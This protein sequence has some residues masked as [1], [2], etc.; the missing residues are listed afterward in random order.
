MVSEERCWKIIVLGL[1][2]YFPLREALVLVVGKFQEGS[3]ASPL[4]SEALIKNLSNLTLNPSTKFPPLLPEYQP[5]QPDRE[6]KFPGL[7]DGIPYRRRGVRTLLTAP[8]ERMQRM[9]QIMKRHYCSKLPVL[10]R[11]P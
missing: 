5:Q 2:V 10:Q 6:K 1:W 11:E 8:K 7:S 3:A 4:I 9:I